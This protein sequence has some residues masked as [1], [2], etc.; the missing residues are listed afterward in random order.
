[1]AQMIKAYNINASSGNVPTEG[2][3]DEILT[4][5]A[6]RENG[7]NKLCVDTELTLDASNV[8]ISNVKVGE[9]NS[10][11]PTLTDGSKTNLQTTSKGIQLTSITNGL[12][13][14][15]IFDLNSHAGFVKITDGVDTADVLSSPV[16]SSGH[17]NGLT[18]VNGNLGYNGTNWDRLR[19]TQN[20]TSNFT[21]GLL[22]TGLYAWTGTGSN[23]DALKTC[24]A[25]S[26]ST[27]AGILKSYN[28]DS[29]AI[30]P[31][32]MLAYD[33]TAGANAY[34]AVSVNSTG[35]FDVGVDGIYDGSTNTDPDNVGLIVHTN[36][37]SPTD[38]NQTVRT[39]GGQSASNITSTFFWGIDTRS[40]LY[41]HTG[42][43]EQELSAITL[44]GSDY[45]LGVGL[46]DASGNRASLVYDGL[47]G[48]SSSAGLPSIAWDNLN[49]NWQ[50]L[51]LLKNDVAANP[52][53]ILAAAAVMSDFDSSGS[54]DYI[55]ANGCLMES[56]SGAIP[57]RGDSTDHNLYV[58]I[59]DMSNSV[60]VSGTG[61]MWTR[62]E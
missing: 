28:D 58:T 20:A 42:T 55:G 2:S 35:K 54:T 18:V 60:S 6:I 44:G 26:D 49:S 24:D 27:Y 16:D 11:L 22:A 4:I 37:V 36:A 10:T 1:M 31:V 39:T 5:T 23:F 33:N 12:D 32:L 13:D 45:G 43:D 7:K 29:S 41:A 56:T 47:G 9:Y 19:T 59:R 21:T 25:L 52:S 38:A 14:T 15:P 40:K 61:D 53:Y 3:T 62:V 17:S 51:R 57:L 46:F 34:R 50:S 8:Y 30:L 48:G